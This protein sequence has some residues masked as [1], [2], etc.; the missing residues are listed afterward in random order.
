MSN[1]KALVAIPLFGMG[2]TGL[3]CWFVKTHWV[4]PNGILYETQ[5][6]TI[7]TLHMFTLNFYVGACDTLHSCQVSRFGQDSPDIWPYVLVVSRFAW[8]C[9]IVPE[10]SSI[11]QI[12][13]W[14]KNKLSILSNFG[15]YISMFSG[16]GSTRSPRSGCGRP[17]WAWSLNFCTHKAHVIFISCFIPTSPFTN[18]A[19]QLWY[20]WRMM[21][22]VQPIANTNPLPHKRTRI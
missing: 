12:G 22:H 15:P 4:F 3:K 17:K 14:H 10:S 6:C 21:T 2:W 16:H 13:V 18:L 5:E 7:D 8:F 19:W 1:D 11:A 20:W 9:S